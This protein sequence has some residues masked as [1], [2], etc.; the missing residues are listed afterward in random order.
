MNNDV[1]I[2]P[3]TRPEQDYFAH[4]AQGRFMLQRSRSSGRFV[5]Y[6]RVAEPVTGARDLEWVPASGFGTVYATTVVRPRPP[7][8]PYNV[9]LVD[10]DEGPRMM[11]RVENMPAE[12]VRIGMRVR[13]RV[14]T[15]DDKPLVVFDAAEGV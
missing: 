5:F 12:A 14:A 8:Q 1:S 15:Q 11:S 9:V 10:L 13:A 6:P 3:E 2:I 7:Q 4:L